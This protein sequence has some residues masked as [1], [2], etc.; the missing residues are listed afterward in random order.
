MEQ[1]QH[2]LFLV[3]ALLCAAAAVFFGPSGQAPTDSLPALAA[4]TEAASTPP[5]ATPEGAFEPVDTP[6]SPTPA[7]PAPT[8]ASHADALPYGSFRAPEGM[9]VVEPFALL[10]DIQ[11]RKS[12]PGG[13]LK[14][15]AP[16]PSSAGEPPIQ[17][18]DAD[19]N[20]AANAARRSAVVTLINQSDVEICYVYFSPSDEDTWGEDWLGND[21][22]PPGESRDIELPVGTYDVKAEDCDGE[23]IDQHRNVDISGEMNWTIGGG[24][25]QHQRE[26]VDVDLS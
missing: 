10:A 19:A 2:P 6:P 23:V 5:A 21:S 9:A 20:L 18:V 8:A 11:P 24:E 1:R 25:Q 14:S 3:L 4:A 12:R 13:G 15:P 26:P 16:D 17:V 7:P 22:V